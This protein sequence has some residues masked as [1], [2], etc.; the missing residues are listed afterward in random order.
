M[1]TKQEVE[2]ETPTFLPDILADLQNETD[3][4]RKTLVKI[5]TESGRLDEFFVN[6]QAF[7]QL[8]SQTTNEVLR[9]QVFQGIEYEEIADSKWEMCRLEPGMEEVIERYASRL[10]KV[11]NENKTPFDHVEFDSEIEH[12]FAKELDNNRDVRFYI[13]L[14]TWFRVDTPVGPYNPDWAIMFQSTA[15]LYLVRETKGSLDATER[16]E[17]EN[18]KIDCATKHFAAIDVNYNVIRNMDDL[19]TQLAR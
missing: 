11:Q 12:R 17:V 14:P 16:R 18:I 7:L 10:Y 15:K 3:L 6:P 4:T 13:K 1:Q 8:V 2:T 9:S 19:T 5:L